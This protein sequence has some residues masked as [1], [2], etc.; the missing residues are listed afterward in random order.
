M[1]GDIP[2][3]IFTGPFNNAEQNSSLKISIECV[4]GN[5]KIVGGGEFFSFHF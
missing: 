4:L 3:D 2:K 5:D 1:E